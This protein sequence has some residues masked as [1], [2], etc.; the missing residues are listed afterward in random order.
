[1]LD[2]SFA[3]TVAGEETRVGG[4]AERLTAGRTDYQ[5]GRQYDVVY[6]GAIFPGQGCFQKIDQ[7]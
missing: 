6:A 1:M 4:A 3:R 7:G 5:L 2:T